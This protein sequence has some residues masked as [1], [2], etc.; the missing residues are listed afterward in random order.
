MKKN[1]CLS[2]LILSCTFFSGCT[3]LGYFDS[4]QFIDAVNAGQCQKAQI[5]LAA[6]MFESLEE[7]EFRG[8]YEVRCGNRA[9]GQEYL[10]KAADSGSS[11]AKRA[12]LRHGM[13]LPDP[14]TPISGGATPSI[15]VY[16]R[17]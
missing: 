16:I 7:L 17:R 9:K 6:P 5:L 15:D 8:I 10:T 14:R 11:Y 3:A 1:L 4:S 13:P 2:T 12:L